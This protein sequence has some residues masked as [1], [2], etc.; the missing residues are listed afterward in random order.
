[1]M[2]VSKPVHV[3]T[4]L[5]TVCE[6]ACWA[7]SNHGSLWAV[8]HGSCKSLSHLISMRTNLAL[9]SVTWG[10]QCAPTFNRWAISELHTFNYFGDLLRETLDVLSFKSTEV[11]TSFLLSVGH[12]QNFYAHLKFKLP[13]YRCRNRKVG[14]FQHADC[15]YSE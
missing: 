15:H 2:T 6:E 4:Q 8:R 13:V 14:T 5:C 12:Q 9:A 1:M 11:L 10:L 7:C 3:C